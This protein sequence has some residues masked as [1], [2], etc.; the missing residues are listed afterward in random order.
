MKEKIKSSSTFDRIV[1]SLSFGVV[2]LIV[3]IA[4]L[5]VGTRL[6][7]LT[8]YAVLSGS[9]EPQYAV[10]SLI[11]VKDIETNNIQV[12]DPIT[13]VLNKELLVAT[14]RV[15]EITPEGSFITKGD[16]NESIDGTPVHPN[17]VLGKPIFS[18]PYLGYLSV[19]L[20]SKQGKIVLGV[21]GT[22]ILISMLI[23][24]KSKKSEIVTETNN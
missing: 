21:V 5:L 18:I 4:I 19:F 2:T 8:P 13:F 24:E 20:S 3:A 17:N 16:S 12:G 9:M 7:G 11:Y 1:K 14:H 6:V 15:V 23:P 22:L 10:G